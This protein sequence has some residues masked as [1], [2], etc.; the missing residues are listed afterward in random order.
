MHLFNSLLSLNIVFYPYF[1]GETEK[2]G[3][4]KERKKKR[5]KKKLTYM[6][7]FFFLNV[8]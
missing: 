5:K 2:D 4:R 1:E 6:K 3:E 7:V 8:F